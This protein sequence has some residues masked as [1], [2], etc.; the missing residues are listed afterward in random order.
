MT[1]ICGVCHFICDYEKEYDFIK[2]NFEKSEYCKKLIG[3]ILFSIGLEF[4]IGALQNV[5]G[6]FGGARFFQVAV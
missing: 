6:F 5:N 4:V 2:S 1:C 3:S